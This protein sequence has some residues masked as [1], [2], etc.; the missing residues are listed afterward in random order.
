MHD[1]RDFAACKF[2]KNPIVKISM[3]DKLKLHNAIFI[4]HKVRREFF[5]SRITR[6]SYLN[7]F[8]RHTVMKL[9]SFPVPSIQLLMIILNETIDSARF[10]FFLFPGYYAGQRTIQEKNRNPPNK[11]LFSNNM[12]GEITLSF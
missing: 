12:A 4:H 7:A 11:R 1:G 8:E 3:N 5:S 10:N 9:T 6:H 2:K